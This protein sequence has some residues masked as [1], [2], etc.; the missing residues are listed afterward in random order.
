L[1]DGVAVMGKTHA[2]RQFCGVL[3]AVGENHQFPP[4]G[5][6]GTD[7][8]EQNIRKYLRQLLEAGP[9]R[10]DR[11]A[12]VPPRPICVASWT[13]GRIC[14]SSAGRKPLWRGIK[15]VS[16]RP[17]HL[18]DTIQETSPRLRVSAEPDPA[19][20]GN[21]KRPLPLPLHTVL[22]PLLSGRLHPVFSRPEYGVPCVI[23]TDR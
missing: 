3:T 17:V 19:L 13:T 14:A 2:R 9:L 1:T 5:I 4:A 10:P 16:A 12:N 8:A 7:L 21:E 23:R 6:L 18:R 20:C 22:R 15:N 11:R